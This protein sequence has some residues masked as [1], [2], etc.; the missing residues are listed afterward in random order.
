MKA[1][2]VTLTTAELLLL[3]PEVHTR[4][5]EQVTPRCVQQQDGNNV[6][7]LVNE[8][9]FMIDDPFETYINTIRPGKTPKPFVAAKD[10]HS[11]RSVMVNINGHNPIKA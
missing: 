8:E 1:P 2:I 5:K 6:P 7:H 10:S 4:W 9:L 3:S 11:I